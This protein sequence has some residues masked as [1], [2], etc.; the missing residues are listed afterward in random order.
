M[1]GLFFHRSICFRLPPPKQWGRLPKGPSFRSSSYL[2]SQDGRLNELERAAVDLDQTLSG[3][4]VGDSLRIPNVSQHFC[5][6]LRCCEFCR[7]RSRWA[8]AVGDE[9]SHF[10]SCR[11]T[12]LTGSKP[13]LRCWLGLSVVEGEGCRRRRSFRCDGGDGRKMIFRCCPGR[14]W[15]NSRII[16]LSRYRLALPPTRDLILSAQVPRDSLMQPSDD[17]DNVDDSSLK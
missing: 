3:L 2:G 17:N 13:L 12:E 14:L 15:A 5:K 1:C 16:H 7:I 9:P 8:G 4:G 11:S 10:A 6:S